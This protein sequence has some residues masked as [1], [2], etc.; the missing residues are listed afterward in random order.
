MQSPLDTRFGPPPGAYYFAHVSVAELAGALRAGR[1]SSRDLAKAALGEAARWQPVLNAFVTVDET[2]ALEAA[3]QAAR[4]MAAGVDRGPLHGIPVAV[5]DVIDV[6][7]LPTTSGSRHFAG[8]IAQEDA[9][10][11]RHLRAA[12]AVI[13]GKTNTHEVA[14]GPTGDRSVS[15]PTRN[16]YATDRIAGAPAAGR[17]LRW[18]PTSSRSPS[19]PTPAVRRASPPR[20]A[21]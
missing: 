3:D 12:G 5:K 11:V 9:E 1:V 14:N 4:E 16:P 8:H 2:G 17:S 7:G 15:G 18:P 21:A 20:A 19:A 10:C 6:R 13:V